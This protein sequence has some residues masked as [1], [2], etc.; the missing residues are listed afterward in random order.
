[1]WGMP[2]RPRGAKQWP[3][4]PALR[5]LAFLTACSARAGSRMEL[6]PLRN[7]GARGHFRGRRCRAVRRGRARR[8][9]GSR[10]GRVR[11]RG[12]PGNAGAWGTGP[13]AGSVV[14]SGPGGAAVASGLVKSLGLNSPDDLADL[15]PERL[16]E[17]DSLSKQIRLAEIKSDTD[18]RLAQIGVNLQDSKSSSIFVAG[19]RPFCGWVAGVGLAYQFICR[20]IANAAVVIANDGP[21]MVGEAAITVFPAIDIASLSA[22]LVGM[23]G[24]GTKRTIEKLK[25]VSRK[26]IRE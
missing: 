17:L 4:S 23:L 19:W 18:V 3:L 6:C 25:G 2:A 1:L 16:S 7:K 15:P 5:H 8:A 26:R 12:E 20:P 11:L 21:M 9:A 13:A 22:L 14:P 10:P 24:L